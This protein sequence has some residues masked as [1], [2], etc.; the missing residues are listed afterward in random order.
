MK[1]LERK[2]I[3]EKFKKLMGLRADQIGPK[4][5]LINK[6][7]VCVCIHTKAQN[8]MLNKRRQT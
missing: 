3:I 2:R 8:I 7:N 6:N 4:R 1:I 5:D